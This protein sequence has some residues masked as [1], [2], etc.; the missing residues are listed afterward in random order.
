[1]GLRV[2]KVEAVAD[3]MN[4][5][6]LQQTFD[7]FLFVKGEIVTFAAFQMDGKLNEAYYGSDETEALR[8]RTLALWSQIRPTAHQLIK[9]KKLPLQFSFVL[10]LSAENAA[11]LLEKYHLQQYASVLKGLY[12]NIRF[13][14]KTLICTTGLSYETFVPDR[15]LENLWDETA[16]KFLKQHEIVISEV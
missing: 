12:L 15:T 8:G 1:M 7:K 5:L 13:R 14:E 10:Q 3:F 6:L 4:Q 11:W 2:Y 16:G 9:G